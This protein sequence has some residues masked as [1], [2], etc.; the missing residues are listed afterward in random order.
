VK[1]EELYIVNFISSRLSCNRRCWVFYA[2]DGYFFVGFIGTTNIKKIPGKELTDHIRR[3]VT[4]SVFYRE[5]QN[6]KE[7]G[8]IIKDEILRR[9]K[10]V[11][12]DYRI[13]VRKIK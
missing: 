5:K 2:G 9:M 11:G 10:G 6:N 13:H 3:T 4:E 1:G 12:D 7:T 8:E